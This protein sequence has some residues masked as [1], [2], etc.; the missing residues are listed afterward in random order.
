LPVN[1][2]RDRRGENQARESTMV[3]HLV[4]ILMVVLAA[5]APAWSDVRSL[6]IGISLNCPYGLAG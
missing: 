3:R 4:L 2:I 6:T 1:E 5:A